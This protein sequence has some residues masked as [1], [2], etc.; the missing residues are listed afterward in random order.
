MLPSGAMDISLV[1]PA[2]NELDNLGP[3]M[4]LCVAALEPFEGDHEIMLIDDGGSDGTGAKSTSWPRGAALRP[5][6]HAPGKNIGC[7]PSE[8][9]GFKAAAETSR[10]SCRPT[11]RSGPPSYRGSS[12]R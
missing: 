5:I 1:I 11:C 10:C 3:L 8:L 9:E 4:E 12:A 2:Y 6:H 7:H